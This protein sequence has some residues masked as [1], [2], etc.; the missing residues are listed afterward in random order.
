MD[1]SRITFPPCSFATQT[2]VGD[3]AN[4]LGAAA[5]SHDPRSGIAWALVRL[6]R[7]RLPILPG[8]PNVVVFSGIDWSSPSD[9]LLD[10]CLG[11][12]HRNPRNAP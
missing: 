1:R 12:L 4:Y 9:L 7:E 11:R 3:V 5:G 6:V 2:N 10:Q 8:E